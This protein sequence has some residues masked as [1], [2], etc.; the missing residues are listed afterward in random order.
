M[1][2]RFDPALPEDPAILLMNVMKHKGVQLLKHFTV[3]EED[4]VR[5]RTL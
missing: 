2:F 1:Y 5:Q 3:I 4:R